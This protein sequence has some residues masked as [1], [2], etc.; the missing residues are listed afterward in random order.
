MPNPAWRQTT[1]PQL[2]PYRVDVNLAIRIK[3]AAGNV[4]FQKN[5][6]LLS[7]LVDALKQNIKACYDKL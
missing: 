3:I 2:Q 5:L 1:P 4:F 7:F 6:A